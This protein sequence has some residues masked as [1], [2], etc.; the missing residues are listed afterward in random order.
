[1]DRAEVSEFVGCL[2]RLRLDGSELSSNEE[3]CAMQPNIK[4]ALKQLKS[5]ASKPSKHRATKNPLCTTLWG[6]ELLQGNSDMPSPNASTAGSY[7]E[8]TKKVM[9]TQ[10]SQLVVF[11][12]CGSQP[13]D[14]AW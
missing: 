12:R 2:M 14:V 3:A 8:S 4:A 13:T 5:D 7:I 1:M 6:W 11:C 9:T 10:R